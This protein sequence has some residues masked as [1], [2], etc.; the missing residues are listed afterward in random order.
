[1]TNST[2]S[3]IFLED[4]P[5][6]SEELLQFNWYRKKFE[7]RLKVLGD[8]AAQQFEP[9]VQWMRQV[10]AKKAPELLEESDSKK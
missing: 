6:P 7:D 5:Y 2:D 9:V 3:L 8:K 1:M 10:I 4:P